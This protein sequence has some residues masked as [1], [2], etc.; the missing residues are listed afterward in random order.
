LEAQR[1][2]LKQM[3]SSNHEKELSENNNEKSV[4]LE[5]VK[6]EDHYAQLNDKVFLLY[7]QLNLLREQSKLEELEQIMLCPSLQYQEQALTFDSKLK[8]HGIHAHYNQL[9]GDFNKALLHRE[10]VIKILG[11]NP[12]Q[13]TEAPQRYRSELAN[14]LAVRHLTG[15]YEGFEEL[16]KKIEEVREGN[17]EENAFTFREVVPLKQLYLLNNNRMEEAY[18]LIPEI[19]KGLETFTEH[20][21]PVR[22]HSFWFNN[23]ITCLLTA[24]YK[25]ALPWV[26]LILSPGIDKKVRSDL[27]DFTYILELILHY[28]IQNSVAQKHNLLESKL[29]NAR[30]RLHYN[31]KL[32][33]FI[34]IVLE[35]IKLLIKATDKA[36]QKHGIFNNF[37][38]Q[39]QTLAAKSGK[40]MPAGRHEKIT[41]LD[42]VIAWIKNK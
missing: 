7:R 2:L 36:E 20:I 4:C 30:K 33:E 42:E 16:L 12:H 14:L 18:E 34:T 40:A 8:F 1:R 17:L 23:A 31:N 35:N 27:R 10:N 37:K 3:P 39:L 13:I 6:N 19:K 32:S 28:E 21:N 5:K 15:N 9:K 25:E 41:G 38:Q 11:E 26:E 22:L 24:N 29:H